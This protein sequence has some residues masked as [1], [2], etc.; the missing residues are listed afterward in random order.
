MWKI[1]FSEKTSVALP[2]LSKMA[3]YTTHERGSKNT[4]EYRMFFKVRFF[5]LIT[6]SIYLLQTKKDIHNKFLPVPKF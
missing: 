2:K 1:L 3:A 5:E 4:L 6:V